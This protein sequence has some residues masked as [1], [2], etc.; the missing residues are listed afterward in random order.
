MSAAMR[1]R[2][3]MEKPSSMTNAADNHRGSAPTTA[4]SFTVPFTARSP[5]DPPGKRHG[6]TTNE[7]VVKAMRSPAGR[8][9]IVASTN[10]ASPWPSASR[11]T[12]STRASEALPP[13]PWASVTTSSVSRGRRR[14]N[15]S[16]RSRTAASRSTSSGISG[17]L[18]Q[19][20]LDLTPQGE[21]ERR[22]CLLDAVHAVAVDDEAVVEPGGRHLASVVA[23]NADRQHAPPRRLAEGDQQVAGVAAGRQT[24]G[25]VAAAA[26]RD[27]LAGEDEL[28]ADVV[29]QGCDYG[30]V[31][32][33]AASGHR[34][35]G[36][37]RREQRSERRGIGRTAAIAERVQPP[38]CPQAVRH[39]A[40][41]GTD[42][43]A[44]LVEC[45]ARDARALDR[46]RGRRLG[47][48]DEQRAG[49]A[50]VSLDEGVQE[51]ASLRHGG[52]RLPRRRWLRRHARA[53]ERQAPPATRA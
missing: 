5:I 16:M 19:S 47:Q 15:D 37:R 12:A 23:G 3:S 21:T 50:L 11:N 53:R 9:R 52:R 44:V 1:W 33:Q 24:E 28:E 32:H 35:P 26:V 17:G 27:Q 2:S 4:K 20:G 49:V 29:A 6:F 8:S 38:A 7:S 46:L 36:W 45:V 14:R 43:V 40:R 10:G 18:V 51:V 22:L 42:L 34:L 25:D 48:I 13:A 39:R 30:S 31:V 41:R